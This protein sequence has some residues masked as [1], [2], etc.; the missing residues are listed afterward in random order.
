[1]PASLVAELRALLPNATIWDAAELATRDPGFDARNF[2]ASALVRPADTASVAAL[3]KFCAERGIGLVAQGGRTGL[4]GGA[5]TSS[6]QVICDLGGLN[7][8]EEIDPF[9][10]VAIVQ[11]GATL[12][13]LQ[14]AAAQH[15]LDPG[16]DLAARGSATIGGMVSTNAG[17]IMAFRNGTMRHRVLGLEAVLPDGR[18]FSDLTQVLKTSAGY[19]LKLL[20]IGA[21]GTLGIVTRVALR[22]DPVAGA[23]ATALVGVPDAASAQRI[24]R[25]FL[26][27]TG[28]RLTAAEILWRRFAALMQR[29][30]GYAPGQLP[31]DAPCL[32]V[33]GLGADSIEAART[34]LEDG[35]AAIWVE[36]GIVDALVAASEAQAA[37][38][39][40]LREETEQ[41]ERAHPLAPS[42]DVSVPAGALDAYVARIEAGL[43]TLDASYAPYVYGHLAD[44]NLHISI[45]CDG[46]V[47]H[48]RHE[49]IEDVLYEGLN[50]AGGSFSAEH[51]IGLDKREAYERH[52]D[53]VKR[54]LARA[55]KA[56]IDPGNVMNPGK[57]VSGE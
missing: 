27:Q 49:A 1:M 35:L 16:I 42:F 8:I 33:L 55:I 32:L 37:A 52:A 47:P 54:E 46:Q 14:E 19:D 5:A 25:H 48:E 11:A 15:G 28:T 7:Q 13:A 44:G 3:V 38:M 22:L 24:V 50:E 45:N 43:K 21:E 4:A 36:A 12:G 57:V 53:P 23:S 6:G 26:S 10:R 39:W 56:M 34:A 9:A 30:L 29:G 2:G 18:V 51:G 40:R 17:G 31:L 20:F 41:I